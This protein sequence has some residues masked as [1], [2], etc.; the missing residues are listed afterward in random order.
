MTHYRSVLD[1]PNQAMC[2]QAEEHFKGPLERAYI[3]DM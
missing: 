1:L 3:R 2:R